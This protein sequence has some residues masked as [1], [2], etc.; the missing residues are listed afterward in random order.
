MYY[1]LLLCFMVLGLF[2][3]IAKLKYSKY[4]TTKE[5]DNLLTYFLGS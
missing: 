5:S 3:G 2:D 4:K 1:L